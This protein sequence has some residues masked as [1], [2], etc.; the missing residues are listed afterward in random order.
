MADSDARDRDWLSKQ[1]LARALIESAR[2]DQAPED[3][4][5]RLAA[6][7]CTEREGALFQT[8]RQPELGPAG[9]VPVLESTA[10]SA[11]R[12][13]RLA[14]ISCAAAAALV[15]AFIGVPRHSTRVELTPDSAVRAP[16]P[17]PALTPVLVPS[18]C[19]NPVRVGIAQALIDDFQDGNSRVFAHAGRSG[20]WQ[21]VTSSDGGDVMGRV[22]P[23]PIEPERGQRALRVA[24]PP[25]G[26][27]GA[28]LVTNFGRCQDASAFRGVRFRAKGPAML[29]VMI[30][31]AEVVDR[32]HGGTCV[33][34]CYH[35]HVREVLTSERFATYSVLFDELEQP[36]TTPEARRLPFRSE[37]LQ[38]VA[39]RVA[40]QDAPLEFW[41]DDIEFV[42]E[43]Q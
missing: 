31:M 3:L 6:R 38:G 29:H 19:E 39:F 11:T 25:V 40:A 23:E 42:A 9:A 18:P 41:I 5:T 34:G 4:G 17:A 30:N 32:R 26:G 7:L 10:T 28:S 16:R 2:E 24:V 13:W 1:P 14:I 20:I 12:R 36:S 22:A 35:A 43:E 8:A 21:L 27:W 37:S 33:E 15:I